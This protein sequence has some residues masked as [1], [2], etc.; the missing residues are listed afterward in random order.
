MQM[1]LSLRERLVSVWLF[2]RDTHIR[3]S[4]HVRHNRLSDFLNTLEQNVFVE[5][6]VMTPLANPDETLLSAPYAQINRN[7]IIFVIPY[8]GDERPTQETDVR[9]SALVAKGQYPVVLGAPPFELRGV[10]HF[11]KGASLR[12][13]LLAVHQPF[14]PLTEAQALHVPTG[15]RFTGDVLLVNRSLLET[16]FPE[17]AEGEP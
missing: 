5:D 13:A 10:L 3:G 14:L 16:I 9:R 12:A 6:A 17:P 4:F 7:A 11:A 15:Q 1:D 2:T 8:T